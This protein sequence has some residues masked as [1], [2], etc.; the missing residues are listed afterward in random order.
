MLCRYE[1]YTQRKFALR[2]LCT[3]CSA[4]CMLFVSLGV[5]AQVLSTISG[6]VMTPDA[7]PAAS[8]VVTLENLDRAERRT[9]TAT[10]SGQFLFSSVAAGRYSLKAEFPG[11]E[12]L[13]VPGFDVHVAGAR[14]FDLT[15]SEA[16]ATFRAS[17]EAV[18]SVVERELVAATTVIRRELVENMPLNGRSFQSLIELAPGVVLTKASTVSGGQFSVNGQ[19]SNSNYFLIDGVGGNVAASTAA[20]FSQQAAGTLPGLTVLGGTNSLV[21]L[22]SLQEFRIAT[23]TYAPEYG[24]SPGGQVILVTRSGG[25]RYRGS[26]FHEFRNEKLDANDWFANAAGQQRPPFRLNQFGG[27]FSGPIL[28]P[29]LY[30]GANRTFFFLSYEGLQLR[31]PL[32][33]RVQVPTERAR[34]RAT[35]AIQT[36][37]NAFPLP[38]RPSPFANPDEG[39]LEAAYSDPAQSNIVSLRLDHTIRQN[40]TWFG[41]MSLAPTERTSRVFANQIT[42]TFTRVDTYTTGLTW[43]ATPALVND[44]RANF[45]RSTGGFGW[46]AGEFG[47]AIK[48]P[49]SLLFPSYADRGRAS[50][51]VFLGVFLPGISP[52]NLTQGRS[53]GNQQRQI[54]IVDTVTWVRGA[55]QWKFGAD[56]RPMLPVADFREYG[57]SYNFG[58]ISSAIN[59]GLA[60]VSVQAL[61]PQSGMRFPTYSSFV[62]DTWRIR[63]TLT[64]NYGMRW[65]IVP[66]PRGASG[67]PIFGPTQVSDPLTMAIAPAGRPLW[68]TRWNNIGPRVGIS[69][70]IRPTWVFRAGAGLFHDLGTGQASRGFNS[71]PYNTNRVS[72]NTP[73]PA[74]AAALE[75][76]PFNTNAPYSSEFFL[77]DPALR[78][79]YTIHWSAGI[80]KDWRRIG[81]LDVRYVGNTGRKLLF[82]ELL[83]NRP[84]SAAL[85]LPAT[86]VVNPALFT[87]NSNVNISR[88][89]ASSDYHSLQVQFR[90]QAT[91]N[92][93]VQASYTWAKAIDNFSDETVQG[94]AVDRVS[95]DLDRGPADFDVRHNFALALSYNLP[96]LRPNALLSGWSI[97]TMARARTATPVNVIS[98]ADPLNLGILSVVRPDV[99]AGVPL[100]LDDATVPG[101]RRFNRAAFRNPTTAR[102]GTL[103]RNLLR[104]FPVSQIDFA[105]RRTFRWREKPSIEFRSDFFN[106]LN[107]PNF[108]DPVGT[109]AAGAN[110]NP[111]FGVAQTMLGRSLSTGSG[112]F[113]P[114]FQI[115]G[116]RSIQ[117]S[118]KL[119]F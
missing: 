49:D 68:E 33:Q 108:G 98:G 44:L 73:F 74:P 30:N 83:R 43:T 93:Q 63:P 59:T 4:V 26:I 110:V 100:Y 55:H 10:A 70:Q 8:A 61:A 32:F 81:T 53:I 22:D 21:T 64:L 38:T 99:I 107:R 79:P 12:T 7:R 40:L 16:E 111:V 91:R 52:P 41:R 115:G 77:T 101:G 95:R 113:S 36:L 88:N 116:P 45:S 2:W 29:K 11:Y 19:R 37:L 86:V 54:N 50:A 60:T 31:Q 117:L 102:Q 15:L 90:R 94:G 118:L 87:V 76:L 13:Q 104:S 85:N 75:P 46:D 1:P 25:N 89:R 66:P 96:R 78:Q 9:A 48:P 14:S 82:T 42:E 23:S 35:G 39:L 97:D 28:I 5:N 58:S 72:T 24:R 67:R 103:G 112:G 17:S 20:T 18:A 92:L 57:I 34:Q 84:A 47:G 71:W 119:M 114:L 51:G 65:E 109:F 80:E 62:Q 106:I 3:G 105:V 56:I 27:N 6:R 69:W